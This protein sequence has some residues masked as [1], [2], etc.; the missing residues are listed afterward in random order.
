[1][2]RISPAFLAILLLFNCSE[3]EKLHFT[4][5]SLQ[6][7]ET[8]VIE[9]VFQTYNPYLPPEE[10]QSL[11]DSLS[12][13]Q[14]EK[15]KY[16]LLHLAHAEYLEDHH[17][18]PWSLLDFDKDEIEAL[19]TWTGE[20]VFTHFQQS[21]EFYLPSPYDANKPHFSGSAWEDSPFSR[22]Y[23]NLFVVAE[24]LKS[25]SIEQSVIQIIE[26]IEK[27]FFHYYSYEKQGINYDR[28][29]YD[30][31]SNDSRMQFENRVPVELMFSERAV[32]CYE[33]SQILIAMLRSINI[34]AYSLKLDGHGIAYIPC[35]DRYVHGDHLASS[36]MALPGEYFL[37][38]AEEIQSWAE[39]SPMASGYL[40]L[41]RRDQKIYHLLQPIGPFREG[42][43]L[44][45]EIN[46]SIIDKGDHWQQ[47]KSSLPEFNLPDK[48]QELE[49]SK[50]YN[51]RYRSSNAKIQS[52]REL[53]GW[54]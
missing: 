28:W 50:Q 27:N 32:G 36:V 17:L 39:N 54:E 19:F 21:D 13:N 1:M 3:S 8:Q 48:P 40:D 20:E 37:L 38:S 16:T 23:E 31:I 12:S 51:W 22:E 33:V 35:L 41:L 9:T 4:P 6:L 34:P 26:W 49:E 7:Q 52:L 24:G 10:K 46:K 15:E 2:K 5:N 47:L 11:L 44:Y 18:V 30:R 43:S 53:S 29:H 42:N 25:D 45:F 14:T